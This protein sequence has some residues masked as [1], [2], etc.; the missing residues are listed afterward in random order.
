MMTDADS[1]L[2]LAANE[3][4]DAF[5]LPPSNQWWQQDSMKID[6]CLT[7][8]TTHFSKPRK[9]F[10][11]DKLSLKGTSKFSLLLLCSYINPST[12]CFF[13]VSKSRSY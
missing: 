5:R 13:W 10:F 8:Q 7:T 3:P 9:L 12:D 6:N 11:L 2:K 4:Q 1:Y